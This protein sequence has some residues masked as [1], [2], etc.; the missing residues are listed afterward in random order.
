MCVSY[1][2][3]FTNTTTDSTRFFKLVHI[4]GMVE[5]DEA[6]LRAYE[7]KPWHKIFNGFGVVALL[8]QL[9]EEAEDA[10]AVPQLVYNHFLACKMSGDAAKM[11]YAVAYKWYALAVDVIDPTGFEPPASLLTKKPAAR[12]K[13][14]GKG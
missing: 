14:R 13:A 7:K 2:S 1:E 5:G 6:K 10:K 4:S 8:H 9:R 3:V 12:A 11:V